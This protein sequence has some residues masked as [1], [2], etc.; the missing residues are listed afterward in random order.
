[1][2]LEGENFFSTLNSLASH[3]DVFSSSSKNAFVGGEQSCS[4]FSM[5]QTN[6]NLE[7]EE[8]IVAVNAIYAIA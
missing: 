2:T 1:M 7:N 8:M 3:A 4:H 6:L 5:N